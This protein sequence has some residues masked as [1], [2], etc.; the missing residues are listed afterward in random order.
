MTARAWWYGG[1]AAVAVLAVTFG[2][3]TGVWRAFGRSMSHPVLPALA[4]KELPFEYPVQLWRD[5]V[6]GETMLRVHINETGTVDSVLI[7]ESSGHLGL[8]SAAVAAAFKLQYHPAREG[9]V[10]IAVWA[11]LPIRFRKP[12][13]TSEVEPTP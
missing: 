13:D 9:K 6:E 2:F 3:A 8:D 5:G 10:A 7:E 1:A 4:M 12:P 11:L